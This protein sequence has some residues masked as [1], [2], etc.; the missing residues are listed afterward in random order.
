MTSPLPINPP[1]PFRISGNRASIP[2]S[3]GLTETAATE[4]QL[5][6]WVAAML[7]PPGVRYPADD[8]PPFGSLQ[9]VWQ[10]DA[11]NNWFGHIERD[12]AG[13]AAT[14]ILSCRYATQPLLELAAWVATR[15]GRD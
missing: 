13:G 4:A 9:G 5:M 11:G 6:R 7:Q 1:L 3:P 8:T 10:L 12:T 2:L 14:L 15:V